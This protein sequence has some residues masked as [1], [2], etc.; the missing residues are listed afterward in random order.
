[1]VTTKLFVKIQCSLLMTCLFF[2][3]DLHNIYFVVF[4]QDVI[5]IVFCTFLGFFKPAIV[6]Y[7]RSRWGIRNSRRFFYD[8]RQMDHSVLTNG[9]IN[10][11]CLCVS[12]PSKPFETHTTLLWQKPQGVK[13]MRGTATN[14]IGMSYFYKLKNVPEPLRHLNNLSCFSV[15]VSPV[16]MA[17]GE[18]D[19]LTMSW[20]YI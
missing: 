18:W 6:P 10:H 2:L 20:G 4:L 3:H 12:D 9:K 14:G 1:M 5:V 11:I 15:C 8:A 13:L 7:L 19:L 17:T 16:S